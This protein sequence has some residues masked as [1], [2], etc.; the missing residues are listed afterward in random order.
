MKK[1]YC[2]AYLNL[3]NYIQSV[4]E[5]GIKN[6]GTIFFFTDYKLS[7]SRDSPP[8]KRTCITDYV[9]TN[10]SPIMNYIASLDH[11]VQSVSKYIY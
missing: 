4:E 3:F 2:N 11:S 5:H 10:V 6:K 9:T 8:G 7:P 1:K